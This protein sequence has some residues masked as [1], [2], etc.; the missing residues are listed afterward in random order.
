MAEEPR[1]CDLIRIGRRAL[2]SDNAPG[3]FESSRRRDFR[4][5]ASEAEEFISLPE[6]RRRAEA[7]C[8]SGKIFTW[9]AR[10]CGASGPSR[11]PIIPALAAKIL[12][13]SGGILYFQWDL[14]EKK[15]IT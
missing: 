8:S 7:R 14:S 13:F 5:R 12:T 9:R 11:K 4:A 15:I 2:D 6:E 3:V 1:T 10:R